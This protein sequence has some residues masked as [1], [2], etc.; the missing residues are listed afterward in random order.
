MYTKEN[1][2]DHMLDFEAGEILRTPLD[3]VILMLKEMLGDENATDVL[4]SCIEPPDT[5][6]IEASYKSLFEL[7]FITE[8]SDKGAISELGLFAC[9][10]GVDL[11]LCSLLGLAI[12]FGVGAEAVQ[13]VAVLS[14]PKTPWVMS[15]PLI[16]GPSSFNST[17]AKTFASKCHFDAQLYSDQFGKMNLLYEFENTSN[18]LKWCER[19]GVFLPRIKRLESTYLNLR[20]RVAEYLHLKDDQLALTKPPSQLSVGQL[21]VLRAIHVWVFHE[22]V[23]EFDPSGRKPGESNG[24]HSVRF[25]SKSNRIEASHIDKVLDK[26]KDCYR[27]AGYS[28]VKQTGTFAPTND[29]SL[30]RFSNSFEPRCIS[31]C[32]DKAYALSV[33]FFPDSVTMYVRSELFHSPSFKDKFDIRVN[34]KRFVA[35]SQN[36]SKPR[37]IEERSCG[38]WIVEEAATDNASSSEEV[39]WFK[40]EN[41]FDQQK[42]QNKYENELRRDVSSYSRGNG[43]RVLFFTGAWKKGN[44]ALKCDVLS[45][46]EEKGINDKDLTD[47]F[48]SSND[49]FSSDCKPGDQSIEFDMEATKGKIMTNDKPLVECIPEGARLLSVLASSRRRE[50]V[51]LFPE[52]V[53]DEKKANTNGKD[54]VLGVNDGEDKA[55]VVHLPANTNIAKRWKRFNSKSGVYVE[56]DSVPASA[57]PTHPT[58]VL[59]CCAANTL[60]VRGGGIR[61]EG[62]TMLPPGRLFLLLCR[63]SMGLFDHSQ[64]KDGSI[65]DNTT[66][67]IDKSAT[68]KE[69]KD[70]AARLQ[71]AIE[72]HQSSLV[73]QEQLQC[74]PDKVRELLSIFDGINGEDVIEWE[75]LK[76]DPFVQKGSRPLPKYRRAPIESSNDQVSQT[77]PS[78]GPKAPLAKKKVTGAVPNGKKGKKDAKK[79][80]T[81]KKKPGKAKKPPGQ[82]KPL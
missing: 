59:Y 66:S 3:S 24:S 15:N 13:M 32:T 64:L 25:E 67:W 75:G 33:V 55:L 34:S 2:R 23:I 11:A 49:K 29:P 50:H 38:L 28:E 4:S 73:L 54:K 19:N 5:T 37:G 9:A 42:K 82:N 58:K 80:T 10:L 45:T 77:D 70:M 35:R 31:Y 44:D 14:F 72:L 57:V 61:A 21:T 1:Y 26:Y 39:V 22:T 51:I 12:Q 56:V 78:I 52:A 69:K 20:R 79:T 47:L 53:T 76:S 48:G 68:K 60:E 8:P 18:K 43:T 41:I 36:S 65:Y 27:L 46:W 40:L 17:V 16:H 62:L 74:F 71:K 30:A 63:F 6:A 81:K 7:H